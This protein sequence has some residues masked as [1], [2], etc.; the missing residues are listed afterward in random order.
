M[1]RSLDVTMDYDAPVA[2]VAAMLADPAFREAVCERQKVISHDVSI[3]P[4]GVGKEVRIEQV[5]EVRNVPG[6][7]KRLVGDEI[8]LIQ[9]ESWTSP[10][11]GD[12]DVT[13]PE[14]PV[15]AHGTATLAATR[16]GGTR[17]T[18]HLDI[19]VGVPLVGGK[20]EGLL[21]DLLGAAL[22]VEN[23]VGVNYLSTSR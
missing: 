23:E 15:R 18:V 16:Q 20:I 1:G 17:E 21:R 22:K 10:E 5:H 2:S 9:T 8:T 7:A 13:V 11:A 6:F 19:E 4:A 3:T 12:I 14:K